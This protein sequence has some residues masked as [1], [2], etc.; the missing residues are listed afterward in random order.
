MIGNG[1]VVVVRCDKMFQWCCGGGRGGGLTEMLLLSTQM[2]SLQCLRLAL[3]HVAQEDRVPHVV[4]VHE[5]PPI[6][7]PLHQVALEMEYHT[8]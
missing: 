4:A 3:L 5:H 1:G 2:M 6:H 7:K 8:S